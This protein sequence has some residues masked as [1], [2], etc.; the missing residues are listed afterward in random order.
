MN[1]REYVESLPQQDTDDKYEFYTPVAPEDVLQ[2]FRSFPCVLPKELGELYK[3]TNGISYT[4]QGMIT[5]ILIWP[6][7]RVIEENIKM[8]TDAN[9]KEI[10]MPFDNFLFFAD[11][12]NGDL[13]GFAIINEKLYND[14]IFAWN[15]EDDSRT[16]VAPSLK[17]FIE[18]WKQGQIKI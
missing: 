8:R 11:S 4:W 12:G 18:W 7:E 15:H 10:Y 9:Y 14:K 16:W 2:Y 6:L 17:I 1:W 5:G 13:F 3:Q